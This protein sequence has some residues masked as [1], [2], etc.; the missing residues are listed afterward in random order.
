MNIAERYQTDKESTVVVVV[1][2]PA[3]VDVVR[4]S[5][6]NDNFGRMARFCFKTECLGHQEQ[7]LWKF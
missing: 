6:S 3:C 4:M 7:S 5:S 1:V 2:A